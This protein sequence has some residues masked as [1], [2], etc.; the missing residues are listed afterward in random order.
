M[1]EPL[2]TA[3]ES[4]KTQEAML[5]AP[6]GSGGDA[7]AGGGGGNAATAAASAHQHHP[8]NL[9]RQSKTEI[10][11]AF[12]RSLR[13]RGG[14]DVDA[15]GVAASIRSHFQLLPSRCV[16]FSH[17][18]FGAPGGG[19]TCVLVVM[20]VP[21]LSSRVPAPLLVLFVSCT[22][23]ARRAGVAGGAARVGEL[24]QGLETAVRWKG[25]KKAVD[26]LLASSRASIARSTSCF[27]FLAPASFY[28]L[29]PSCSPPR[30]KNLP[31]Q[32]NNDNSYALDVNLASLD[33]LNHKR[34]L[35]SARAD[36]SAVSFQVRPVDVVALS[37]AAT[38]AG[39]NS[40]LMRPSS[41]I[42]GRNG[43]SGGGLDRAPS[44]SASD[45]L[46]AEAA[47]AGARAARPRAAL[48]RPA[49]GSSPNLQ[50]SDVLLF[51]LFFS[52]LARLLSLSRLHP[53][54]DPSRAWHCIWKA[55]KA[56]EGERRRA[57]FCF[58]LRD[59]RSSSP[60]TKDGADSAPPLPTQPT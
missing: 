27:S 41:T 36:P 15:P 19:V 23:R 40:M 14:L 2:A 31:N 46:L 51:F 12:V 39:G 24:A 18:C 11:D 52:F 29:N 37:T 4:S 16:F 58:Q 48:P 17:S 34:L 54:A 13:E 42:E 10:A 7:I 1:H 55:V 35:D 28:L 43:N 47:A 26:F 21:V 9:R 38:A 25:K 6:N 44:F 50:V 60:E 53:N 30:P 45:S 33:V 3:R 49:F 8:P 22:L 32:R 5:V 57:N 59:N 56:G 20:T